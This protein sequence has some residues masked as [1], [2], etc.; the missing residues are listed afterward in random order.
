VNGLMLL[1]L[2]YYCCHSAIVV[3]STWLCDDFIATVERWVK[4]FGFYFSQGL[5]K[6]HVISLILLSTANGNNCLGIC[7]PR[8]TSTP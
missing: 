1:V 6:V 5:Q 3:R 4:E 8:P 7:I 2:Q